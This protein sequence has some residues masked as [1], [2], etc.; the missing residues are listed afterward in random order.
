M[1]E[2]IDMALGAEVIDETTAGQ[3]NERLGSKTVDQ[4]G[5][6]KFDLTKLLGDMPGAFKVAGTLL[7][8]MREAELIGLPN[9][10]PAAPA[11]PMA[12][13]VVMPT[14]RADMGLAELF[15]ELTDH[16]EDSDELVTLIGQQLAVRQANDKL[17]GTG[18]WAIPNEDGTLNVTETLEYVRHLAAK[19][20]QPQRKWK[21]QYWP[22]T[23]ER[24][25]GRDQRIMLYP[26]ATDT[27]DLL[28]V[29]PDRFGNDW[30]KLSDAVHEA[31]IDAVAR[32]ILSVNTETDIRR[33]T[34]EL[35][36]DELPAY[37]RDIVEDYE[38]R[39]ARGVKVERYATAEQLRAAGLD[40]DS[41]GSRRPFDAEPERDEAWYEAQLRE[42]ALR[43]I[44]SGGSNVNRENCILTT[45]NSGGGNIRLT[46][47]IVLG[48][49]NS[50]GGNIRGTFYQAPGRSVNAGGGND[51][52]VSYNWTYKRL[53]AKAQ[54]LGL[55]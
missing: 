16:P 24:A 47:A 30:S 37:L 19:H 43:A 23:L 45:I 11:Q 34:H 9:A 46:N 48:S 31:I 38:Q 42:I 3:L 7:D 17:R 25:L 2:V 1:R 32:R 28:L 22:T 26:F 54:E 44:N 50:G 6:T 53:Y 15:K 49:V 51:T 14:K 20:T 18:E 29:G 36:S 41:F 33:V 55:I 39:K 8:F 35:F 4:I 52:S 27:R 13:T 12:V 10:A 40:A 21:G 5:T